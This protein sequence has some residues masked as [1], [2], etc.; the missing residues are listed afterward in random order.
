MEGSRFGEQ[1]G[2][3]KSFPKSIGICPQALIS[4]F[5][6]IINNKNKKKK[7][8]N[9]KRPKHIKSVNFSPVELHRAPIEPLQGPYMTAE[10]ES[11]GAFAR[12]SVL[13]SLGV[14]TKG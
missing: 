9:Q 10:A 14:I 12:D 13:A 4:N 8:K 1:I 7:R 3:F 11:L 5:K 2:R 6:T